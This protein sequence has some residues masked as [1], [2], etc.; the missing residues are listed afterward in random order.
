MPEHLEC[1]GTCRGTVSGCPANGPAVAFRG[2]GHAPNGENTR[3][4]GGETSST[5]GAD[6]ESAP[7]EASSR[8]ALEFESD[9]E[10]LLLFSLRPQRL[11]GDSCSIPNPEP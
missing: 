1:Q 10:L 11:C 2:E 5:A 9:S 8:G 6:T 3:S 7:T 4:S